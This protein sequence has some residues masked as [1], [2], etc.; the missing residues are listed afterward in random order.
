MFMDPTY[1]FIFKR[2]FSSSDHLNVP[3]SFINAVCRYK[4]L[5]RVATATFLNQ[6]QLPGNTELR[7]GKTMVDIYCENQRGHKFI[8]EMQRGPDDHLISRLVLYFSRMFASQYGPKR[9]YDALYPVIVIAIALTIPALTHKKTYRSAHF[10]LDEETHER[11]I[12]EVGFILVE[13]D[14]FTKTEAEL[15]TDEDKWLYLLKMIGEAEETPKAFST[16]PHFLDKS[17]TLTTALLMPAV[18]KPIF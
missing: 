5:D 15:E 10:L 4:G 14:K 11:D 12:T 8:I 2:L 3:I 1:D 9:N 7:R 16:K 17:L 6:E 18:S 13:L